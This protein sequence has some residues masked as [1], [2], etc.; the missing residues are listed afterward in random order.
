MACFHH[1]LFIS[2]FSLSSLS[3]SFLFKIFALGALF[4]LPSFPLSLSSLLLPSLHADM[5]ESQQENIPVVVKFFVESQLSIEQFVFFCFFV[6]VFV[7][8][9]NANCSGYPMP[10]TVQINHGVFQRFYF[11]VIFITKIKIEK[12]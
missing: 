1:L 2:F 8:S 3:F 4:L 5:R 11:I 7:F 9:V 12:N 6:L 10:V